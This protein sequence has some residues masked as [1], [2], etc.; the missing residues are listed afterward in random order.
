MIL[1]TWRLDN[2]RLG[3]KLLAIREDEQAADALGVRTTRLKIG[4]FVVSAIAPA[5]VGALNAVY[6]GF[7][8]PPT[9]FSPVM[10]LTTIAIVLLGGMGTVLGPLM[11]AVVLSVVNELLW[12]RFPEYYTAI[13]G[14]L[15][16][17]A[18][19]FMPRGIVN[20]GMKKGWLPAGRGLFRQLA[21]ERGRRAEPAA[22]P[23]RADEAKRVEDERAMQDPIL[24]TEGISKRFEGRIALNDASL[25]VR[26]G[27]ITGV[28][29]PN[30]SG[31][32]T[33]FNIIAGTL[34][35]NSGRVLI[36]GQ[37]VTGASAADI[38]RRGVGR[39]FQISRLFAEMTVMENLVAVAHGIDDRTAVRRA[40]ELLEF[41]E[42]TAIADKW[43]S[44]LSYGQR[45]LVEIARA[46]MLEPVIMLL[47]EPFAGINPRLQNRIVEHLK[48]LCAK[49]LTVFFIDHEMRIVLSE[50][51]LVYVLAEG[52]V[53]ASG[54]PAQV[55]D[56]PK[57]LD[58]YF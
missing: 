22:A 1:A 21:R 16:L 42:I 17:L 10:E 2:S 31:K 29:G 28:I 54:P 18:V 15:V 9:A 51:D 4:T 57:V 33:L 45:K 43:G 14:V 48:T 35:P 5:A 39:T 58:A 19:L 25:A 12:A 27:S 11:G 49:G 30:G 50:C 56:D 24:V 55:R 7:I 26:R 47:D 44:E 53:I 3:L 23:L 6:L 41:L 13:V 32:S 36:E 40:L 37:D 34:A 52:N 46:L 20:L 38:C 8:D